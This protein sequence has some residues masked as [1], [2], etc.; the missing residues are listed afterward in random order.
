MPGAEKA[1]QEA[2]ADPAGDPDPAAAQPEAQGE[3]ESNVVVHT[4]GPAELEQGQQQH[5]LVSAVVWYV[6]R[7]FKITAGLSRNDEERAAHLAAIR[8]AIDN[9]ESWKMHDWL[10]QNLTILDDKTSSILALNSIALAI[11]TFLYTTFDKNTPI[12]LYIGA[13]VAASIFLWAIVP[14]AR[15][16]FVFWSTTQDF[17]D[18]EKMFAE[19]LLVRDKRTAI[20]RGALVKDAFGLTALLISGAV[21]LAQWLA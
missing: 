13:F 11:L 19:L 6:H 7:R 1:A 18:I 16:S 5:A 14:L 21:A 4:P 10:H 9:R 15:V 20:V 17:L 8:S 12:A 3:E 2:Q